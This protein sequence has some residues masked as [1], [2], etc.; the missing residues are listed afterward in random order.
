[1]RKKFILLISLIASLCSTLVSAQRNNDYVLFIDAGSTGS[2]VHLFQYS[3]TQLTPVIDERYYQENK[4]ALSSFA[5]FPD[6][7]GASL[8][9]LLDGSLQYMQA[10]HIAANNIPLHVL[11]TA[12][13]RLLPEEKQK[14]IYTDVSDYLK[15]NYPFPIA[16][17]KTITGEM[18]ALY[19]WLDINYLLQNFQ[20]HRPTVGSIDMGGASTEIAF[21]TEDHSR[22]NDEVTLTIDDQTYTVFSK[23]FLGLGHDQALVKMLA[24]PTAASC[25][26]PNYHFQQKTGRFQMKACSALYANLISQQHV[27]EKLLPEEG[28]NFVA[29]SGFY[30]TYDFFKVKNHPDRF[31]LENHI[32]YICHKSWDE[33]K[34]IYPDIPEKYLSTYCANGVYDDQ[35]IYSAY[36]IN[37]AHLM[38]M[39]ELNGEEIDWP[40]GAAL[41]EW[42][43]G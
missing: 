33:L 21:A 2:R 26:P 1:M 13:M 43:S 23:S 29:Y 38:V 34:K 41:Y 37:K 27:A 12:G 39:N 3:G 8:K 42:V 9:T 30:Y 25:F 40:L 10:H 31:S 19:G 5:S 4:V 11:A 18:E 15:K 17:I 14:L 16:E 22:P 7:A 6:H 24:S 35:L 32:D 28:E 36:K 20:L